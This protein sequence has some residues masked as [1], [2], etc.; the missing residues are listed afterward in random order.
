LTLV[1]F[2]TEP[3]T[4][5]ENPIKGILTTQLFDENQQTTKTTK[6]P[7]KK[8]NWVRFSKGWEYPLSPLVMLEIF[9]IGW[10]FSVRT[11]VMVI[12]CNQRFV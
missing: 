7:K 6:K 2:L 4:R 10:D 3:M 12:I 9:R 8:L 1:Y 11:I 5:K